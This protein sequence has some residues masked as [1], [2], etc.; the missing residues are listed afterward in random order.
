M[1]LV[2]ELAESSASL[3][4]SSACF[5]VVSLPC[6]QSRPTGKDSCN[7][8]RASAITICIPA[9]FGG[10]YN[11]NANKHLNSKKEHAV[12]HLV[13]SIAAVAIAMAISSS[14]FGQTR[15]TLLLPDPLKREVDKIVQDFQMRTHINV[16]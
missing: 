15:I 5:A 1:R 6:A 10:D 13:S 8:K 14:A 4:L 12:K 9:P 16:Q 3:L 2:L 7:A 11:G